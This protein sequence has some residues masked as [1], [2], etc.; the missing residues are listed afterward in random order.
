ME[1]QNE[2]EVEQKM[3]D[4]HLRL[5]RQIRM[6]QSDREQSLGVHPRLRRQER[7][8]AI[9]R[10]EYQNC[11]KDLKVARSGAHKKNDAKMKVDLE[12]ALM[13]REHTEALSEEGVIMMDQLNELL[14]RKKKQMIE[15]RKTVSVSLGKLA[16]RRHLSEH[17][18]TAAEN[19]LETTTSRFNVVQGENRRIRE[20]I[21]HMLKDRALF[22]QAW[23]KMLTALGT[24]KK[25]LEDLFESSTLAY[26][27]RDEWCA[28]LRSVQEKGRMDQMLQ[29][30][31]M[32]DLQKAFDH[33]TK[34][35]HFL[36]RKGVMRVNQREEE[37]EETRRIAEEERNKR[38]M[39]YHKRVLEEIYEYMQEENIRKIKEH[40][41]RGE[42]NHE[43]LYLLVT[44]ICAETEALRR[45]VKKIRENI[46]ERKKWNDKMEEKRVSKIAQMQQ[47][48]EEQR[49]RTAQKRADVATATEQLRSSMEQVVEL[50][51]MLDCPLEPFQPQLGD[52]G[53]GLNNMGL[54]FHLLTQ[55]IRE[56]VEMV[57]YIERSSRRS[58][59]K[60]SR[61]KKYTIHSDYPQHL[62][63][64]T[65]DNLVAANPCPAC[66]EARWFLRV[67]EQLESPLDDSTAVAALQELA[68][69]TAFIRSD[70]VHQLAECRSPLS[71]AILA[72]RYM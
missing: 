58:G 23:E 5:Q 63:V 14:Q 22:N 16:E 12:R 54:T 48:L 3:E 32:R 37:R 69:D 25:F 70:R 33:E 26:D 28:K 65:I 47:T 1:A 71:R 36:A 45:E 35:Y 61:L 38:E 51:K 56:Y 39:E 46:E 41:E 9:L 53:P 18:L 43:S 31:E 34:L 2:R 6:I 62:S 19:K 29:V 4:E 52:K 40:F 72:R 68:A 27:Q 66:I 21:E 13:L 7:L 20:E 59:L 30:Q 10:G 17:R 11:A 8:M 50:F 57:Y 64:S 44:E 67:T 24:G 15:L 42:R 49:Q 60:S 55:R